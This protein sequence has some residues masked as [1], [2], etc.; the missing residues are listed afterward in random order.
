MAWT[1]TIVRRDENQLNFG[2]QCGL[3]WR[4]YGNQTTFRQWEEPS[5]QAEEGIDH[6][7][8]NIDEIPNKNNYVTFPYL[9]FR[10]RCRHCC[11]ASPRLSCMLLVIHYDGLKLF[12]KPNEMEKHDVG[13]ILWNNRPVCFHY[14]RALHMR[15]LWWPDILFGCAKPWKTV[16]VDGWVNQ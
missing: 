5:Y 12:D 9:L 4:F 11:D 1:M 6:C 8:C 16:D 3:Y 14:S 2:I 15:T 10:N 7:S 13:Q